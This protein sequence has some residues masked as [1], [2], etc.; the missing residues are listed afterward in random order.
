MTSTRPAL[1]TAA[2]PATGSSLASYPSST[3]GDDFRELLRDLRHAHLTTGAARYAAPS[4]P[5]RYGTSPLHLRP[6]IPDG[7]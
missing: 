3:T 5:Y 1:A 7:A 6:L 2:G 4:R